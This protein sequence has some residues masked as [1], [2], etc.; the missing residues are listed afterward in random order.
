[1]R[2]AAQERKKSFDKSVNVE[3]SKRLKRIIDQIH[4]WPTIGMVGEE[5]SYAA[6]LIVQHADHDSIFQERCLGLMLQAKDDVLLSNIAYLTDR[7]AVNKGKPQM[8]GTQF[9]NNENGELVPRPIKN[10]KGLDVRRLKVGLEPFLIYK[11]KMR[12]EFNWP[13]GYENPK[14][15]RF[16]KSP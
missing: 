7:V 15:G 9:C 3:N 4:A 13:E 16:N 6:W 8:Y 11:Q 10:P 12:G 5:A 2:Q 14:I 1:M